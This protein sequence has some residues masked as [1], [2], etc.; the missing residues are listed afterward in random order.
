M[1]KNKLPERDPS[2]PAE[3]QG[4]FRKFVVYRADGSSQPGGKHYG[5]EYFV[6]DI[7]HDPYA[8]AA[9]RAYAVACAETHPQLSADLQARFGVTGQEKRA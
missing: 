4:L 3:Q 7:D 5:C 6:L 9:L 1:S 8:A 2:K